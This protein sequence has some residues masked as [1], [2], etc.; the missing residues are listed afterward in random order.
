MIHVQLK[1]I[2]D[3]AEATDGFRIFA[4]RLWARGITKEE[5]ALDLWAKDITPSNELRKWFH[6][7]IEEYDSFQ[8]KYIAELNANPATVDFIKTLQDKSPVTLLTAAK[9]PNRS[10]L[11]VLQDYLRNF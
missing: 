2:Y 10:H 4:D 9:N 6:A 1:R 3:E 5:A 11:S 7:N 8:K